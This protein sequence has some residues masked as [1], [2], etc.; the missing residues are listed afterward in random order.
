MTEDEEEEVGKGVDGF[1]GVEVE[2][3]D[4]NREES[5]GDATEVDVLRI[6]DFIPVANSPKDSLLSLSLSRCCQSFLNSSGDDSTHISL[7]ATFNSAEEMNPE[8]SESIMLKKSFSTVSSWSFVKVSANLTN[9]S[10]L[11]NFRGRGRLPSIFFKT[12]T[13]WLR[14]VMTWWCPR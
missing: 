12:L 14:L 5:A 1:G 6:Q 8:Q 7:R 4:E 13:T 10:A 3:K 11:S 2:D 9:E